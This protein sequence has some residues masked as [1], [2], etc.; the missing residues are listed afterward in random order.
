MVVTLTQGFKTASLSWVSSKGRRKLFPIWPSFWPITKTTRYLWSHL[1][2]ADHKYTV[3][4]LLFKLGGVDPWISFF[5]WF[6]YEL[7]DM[8]TLNRELWP[9]TLL[10]MVRMSALRRTLAYSRPWFP[11]RLHWRYQRWSMLLCYCYHQ[12]VSFLLWRIRGL[13]WRWKIRPSPP[14]SSLSYSNNWISFRKF[15]VRKDFFQFVAM[16]ISSLWRK[17]DIPHYCTAIS[18][19]SSTEE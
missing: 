15:Y 10:I 17:V 8:A 7:K 1:S 18:S 4:F 13:I 14:C 9:Y 16:T 2:L 6:G 19:P 5:A 11:L 12:I 3:D